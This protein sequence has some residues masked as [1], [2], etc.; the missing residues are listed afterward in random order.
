MPTRAFA[1]SLLLTWVSACLPVSTARPD[2]GGSADAGTAGQVHVVVFTHIEDSTPSGDIPSGPSRS[3]Y[4]LLRQRM[5]DTAEAF[6]DHGLTWVFQPDWKVLLAAQAYEDAATRA[7]TGGKNVLQYLR[8]DLGVVVDPHSHEKGGYNYTDVAY[9]LDQ[10][11]VGGS[12]V[13]GGHVWDPSL[14]E[15]AHWDR[16]RT[17]QAG[18]QYPSASWR[19]D[20]LMGHG[21]PN[22]VND[23]TVSGIWRPRDADHFFED[24]PAANITAVGDYTHDVAGISTLLGLY[25]S[26]AVPPTCMLTATYHLLPAALANPSAVEADVLAP[27]AALVAGGRVVVTDFTSLAA[28]WKGTYGA[29]ACIHQE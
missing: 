27:L 28:T 24:N 17:S 12:T 11:G 19:G 26:G 14:P 9:L 23:P 22:H 1:L 21:T 5:L 8:E 2:G 13:I 4:L 3:Q 15:F 29:S 10:L 16:F 25:D 18:S 20:I 6:Q 7:S